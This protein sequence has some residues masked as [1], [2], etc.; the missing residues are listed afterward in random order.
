MQTPSSGSVSTGHKLASDG[1]SDALGAAR[2]LGRASGKGRPVS[3]RLESAV[4]AAKRAVAWV[5]GCTRKGA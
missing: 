2:D 1:G 3:A 5:K 4:S